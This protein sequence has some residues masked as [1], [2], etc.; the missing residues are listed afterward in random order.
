MATLGEA[1]VTI[2]ADLK[3]LEQGFSKA[4]KLTHAFV[5]RVSK[6]MSYIKWGY[7]LIAGVAGISYLTHETIKQE[8]ADI[9][10]AKALEIVGAYSKKSFGDLKSYALIVQKNT[11]YADEYVES[12]MQELLVLGVLPGKLKQA[13]NMTIGLG[14]ATNMGTES[15]VRNVAKAYQGEYTMLSRYIPALTKTKDET[16]KFSMVLDLANRGLGIE[17]TYATQTA[18]GAL[19]QIK[20]TVGDVAEKFGVEF[21]GAIVTLNARLTEWLDKNP[22]KVE[23]WSAAFGNSVGKAMTYLG[24]FLS[25]VESGRAGTAFE[26]MFS[27]IGSAFSRFAAANPVAVGIIGGWFAGGYPG[28][29]IGGGFGTGYKFKGAVE[30]TIG[31]GAELIQANQRLAQIERHLRNQV[32]SVP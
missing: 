12:L 32:G 31:A 20:N 28:A 24:D 2:R 4:E 5:G 8:E 27:D 26:K 22:G 3:Y 9:K 16:K 25:M 30:E 17:T 11:T 19:K 6:A 10:L 23:A 13:V 21:A 18:G 14:A 15:M 29:V 7:G 1:Y